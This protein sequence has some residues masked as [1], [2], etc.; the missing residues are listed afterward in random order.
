MGMEFFSHLVFPG[1]WVIFQK[2]LISIEWDYLIPR[3]QTI[4]HTNHHNLKTTIIIFLSDN[5]QKGRQMQLGAL[6]LS[7]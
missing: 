5:R 3:S 4:F 2:T 7:Y 6:V 1:L